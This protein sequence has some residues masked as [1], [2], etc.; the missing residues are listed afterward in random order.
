MSAVR[1]FSR[2]G[3]THPV[4]IG[5][6]ALILASCSSWPFQ[7]FARKPRRQDG[8]VAMPA[9]LS[10]V[11]RGTQ[12]PR[13]EMS[14]FF[15]VLMSP[16]VAVSPASSASTPSA[17][18]IAPAPP[19]TSAG[20]LSRY[21][22]RTL[23]FDPF[24]H[25]VER[26]R[27][28]HDRFTSPAPS[29]PTPS[30]TPAGCRNSPGSAFCS[31]SVPYPASRRRVQFPS[32]S[33]AQ[34][35]MLHV[36]IDFLARLNGSF[37]RVPGPSGTAL[38]RLREHAAR[39][40]HHL[41]S[42]SPASSSWTSAKP[43]SRIRSSTPSTGVRHLAASSASKSVTC[44]S[45]EQNPPSRRAGLYGRPLRRPL[46]DH[47]PPALGVELKWTIMCTTALGPSAL[48]CWTQRLTW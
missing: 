29:A 42:P 6:G 45:P 43:R 34:S 19:T 3:R 10:P 5:H 2:T 4:E 48:S 1:H 11:R 9:R 7:A 26:L 20:Y 47:E 32:F 30:C 33:P 24:A 14:S 36:A 16:R 23:L 22:F 25:A 35:T 40:S 8:V 18:A 37:A 21:H 12:R 15:A 17:C 27:L 13:G 39:R 44:V 41:W 31:R 46:P 28:E 38:A